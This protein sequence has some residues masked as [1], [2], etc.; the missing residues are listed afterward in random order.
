MMNGNPYLNNKDYRFLNFGFLVILAGLLVLGAFVF[1]VQASG[2]T[3]AVYLT[4]DEEA[5]T[6]AAEVFMKEIN[7]P[8]EIF[9]MHG[10]TKK[11]KEIMAKIISKK[12]SLIF[13][14]GAKAAVSAKFGTARQL[15]IPIVFAKVLNWKKYKLLGQK[16]IA[17]VA[18]LVAPG[19][20]FANL[21][22][23]APNV[24]RIGVI[25][26]KEHSKEI[27]ADAEKAAMILGLELIAEPIARSKDMRRTYEKKLRGRIDALWI[28]ADPVVYT[29][30]NMG[31]LK[32]K[33]LRD[34]LVTVGQSENIVKL[35]V[36]LAVNADDSSIGSRAVSIAKRI[37]VKKKKPKKIKVKSPIGTITILNLDNEKKIGLEI[38]QEIKDMID[39]IIKKK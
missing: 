14:L 30:K 39:I 5:Y 13:A 17:G 1:P 18:T 22:M 4:S 37:L 35:G 38:S 25:Y 19:T 23:V 31:W 6:R 34:K 7:M 2:G 28:L 32:R 10:N 8:V 26:S 29:P 24:K 20:Q 9:N 11:H 3:V 27:V 15:D 36:L 16:N 12:P 21:T 33:S